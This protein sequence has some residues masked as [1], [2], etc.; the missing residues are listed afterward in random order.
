MS[1]R[2]GANVLRARVGFIPTRPQH[3]A[4]IRMEPPPS[5]AWA[6]GTIP[7]AT[8]AAEPPLEPP[9]ERFVA[10]LYHDAG[11][12]QLGEAAA[13]GKAGVTCPDDDCTNAHAAGDAASVTC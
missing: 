5:L 8:A 10:Q 1:P 3:D 13:H 6:T 2:S 11:V 12:L 9:D 7:A 4:G